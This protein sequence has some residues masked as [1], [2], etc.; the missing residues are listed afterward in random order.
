MK[1]A[2]LNGAKTHPLS[3][4]A[5]GVLGM[6]IDGPVP[7]QEIN[8][9]VANRLERGDGVT[10]YVQEVDHPSPYKAHKGRHIAHLIATDA[11]RA[12]W[13]QGHNAVP[14]RIDEPTRAIQ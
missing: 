10:P 6:L 9:G 11:G 3:R 13:Q 2:P 14:G 8:P 7:R 5:L 1:T 4:A 12:A